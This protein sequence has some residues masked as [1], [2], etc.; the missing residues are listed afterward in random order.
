MRAGEREI[1]RE[2]SSRVAAARP[3]SA[4]CVWIVDDT[5]ALYSMRKPYLVE[6]RQGS[7]HVSCARE[8][9]VPSRAGGAAGLSAGV[10]HV[11]CDVSTA[12]AR[13]SA[14]RFPVG[15]V[16]IR[17]VASRLQEFRGVGAERGVL[18]ASVDGRTDRCEWRPPVALAARSGT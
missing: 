12:I 7:L 9:A 2:L 14:R 17:R 16:S 11:E 15:P 4:R 18:A 6:A 8:R 13:D 5:N 3:S 1:R 10:L